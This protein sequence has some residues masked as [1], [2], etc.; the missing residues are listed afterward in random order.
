MKEADLVYIDIYI[1]MHF[2]EINTDYSYII[3]LL[4]PNGLKNEKIRFF[5]LLKSFP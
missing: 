5:C 4:L 3:R 1:D 2:S